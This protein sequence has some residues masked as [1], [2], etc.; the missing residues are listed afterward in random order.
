MRLSEEID[1]VKEIIK[2]KSVCSWNMTLPVG[3]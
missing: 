3:I 1:L 2:E